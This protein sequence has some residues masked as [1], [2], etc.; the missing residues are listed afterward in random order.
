MEI[1]IPEIKKTANEVLTDPIIISVFVEKCVHV[2]TDIE[3]EDG[4]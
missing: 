2:V 4:F 1:L 3:I